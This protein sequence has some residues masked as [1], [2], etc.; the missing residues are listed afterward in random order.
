MPYGV[1]RFG[2]RRGLGVD[3]DR[4]K[5]RVARD[6][7][8]E[9]V[10]GDATHLH[11]VKRVRFV[12]MLDFL[13]HLPDIETAERVIASAAY[14][15][16]DF[17]FIRHPSFEGQER[18]EDQGF[19]QTWWNWTGHTCHLRV[20]DYCEIFDRLGLHCYMVR[21]LGRI[22]D[23]HHAS[24]VTSGRPKDDLGNPPQSVKGK[25]L[26]RFEPPLWRLQDI[27][28]ALRAM[29]PDEWRQITAPT[30]S[31]KTLMQR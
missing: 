14:A 6:S 29:E 2:G 9:A 23:S 10:L 21:Y 31:D 28:V 17:L 19:R 20:S 27:F 22:G 16:T 5:V 25:S 12:S 1:R 7:G 18:V 24:I 30:A 8:V 3:I 15:A 13:E 26:L 11:L 4:A